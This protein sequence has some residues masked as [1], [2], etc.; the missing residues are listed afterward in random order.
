M[1][2]FQIASI[3]FSLLLINWQRVFDTVNFTVYT[4]LFD[5]METHLSVFNNYFTTNGRYFFQISI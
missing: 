4:K 2:S 5:I 1:N 3:L